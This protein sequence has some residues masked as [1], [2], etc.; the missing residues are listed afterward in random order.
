MTTVETF[1]MAAIDPIMFGSEEFSDDTTDFIRKAMEESAIPYEDD[2]FNILTDADSIHTSG[3]QQA[4]SDT[5]S[6]SGCNFEQQ[7]LSPEPCSTSANNGLDLLRYMQ[8]DDEDETPVHVNPRTN[9]PDDSHSMCDS[10]EIITTLPSS[11]ETGATTIILPVISPKTV[12]VVKSSPAPKRR[13]VSASS[14]DSG[15]EENNSV[16]TSKPT[17]KGKYPPLELSEEEKRIC[18]REGIK[19]PSHYPL[20]RE[21]ERN[22]K[23]IRRKIRNKLS[24]QDSRKRKKEY[25]DNMEDRVRACSD[26]NEDLHKRIEQL[27]TQNKT[28]AGQLKRLHQIILSGGFTTRA[29][30][31]S[32]AM[33]VLLLSTA[34]FLIPGLRENRESQKSEIDIT[35]AIKMPPMPGQSR[36][37]LQIFRHA[38]P[39]S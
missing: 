27:E 39:G 13:R 20:S 14:N 31:T 29:N 23:K 28:L 24:A 34:L 21:E 1:D 4:L 5:S 30:Q 10:E 2:L 26:E 3:T 36:S 7:L 32:T 18:E 12:K 11:F 15:V 33:M 8:E 17:K 25:M 9:S 19:L 22:L 6:D 16:A 38:R 35:R 37:L